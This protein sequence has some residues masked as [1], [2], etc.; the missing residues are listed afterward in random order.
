MR[1]VVKELD[2]KGI[3]EL[4]YLMT[5][6]YKPIEARICDNEEGNLVLEQLGREHLAPYCFSRNLIIEER[7][8][9]IKYK[10]EI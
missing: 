5:D 8:E 4:I 3:K 7:I 2:S 9:I 1:I 6:D 10:K